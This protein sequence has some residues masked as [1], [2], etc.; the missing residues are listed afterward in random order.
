MTSRTLVGDV[1][2]N[3]LALTIEDSYTLTN[4]EDILSRTVRTNDTP[5]PTA[6]GTLFGIDRLDA[7][8]II[9]DIRVHDTP[10]NFGS[11]LNQLSTLFAPTDETLTLE[12]S[13]YGGD[14]RFLYGRPRNYN[15]DVSQYGYAQI[16]AQFDC[17]DPRMYSQWTQSI[18][19][20]SLVVAG[21]TFP[22]SFPLSFTTNTNTGADSKTIL[23]AGN[24]AAPYEIYVPATATTPMVSHSPSGKFLKLDSEPQ[25]VG[26]IRLYSPD[27]TI[28]YY[29][30]IP[31]DPVNEPGVN[32]YHWL[33]ADSSWF[34]MEPGQNTLQASEES[35]T[36][37]WFLVNTVD[38]WI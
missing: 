14:P 12:F 25:S 21:L 34:T 32:V 37:P 8:K 18:L 36:Q 24:I 15:V 17:A 4:P 5:H 3:G 23:N 29:P 2:L 1:V 16:K 13:L 11:V 19:V 22:L 35:G 26:W 6:H 7:R 9:F 38:T 10:E 28:Q 33:T 27:R 20:P 30:D 31:L